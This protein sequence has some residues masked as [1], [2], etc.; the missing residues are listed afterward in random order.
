VADQPDAVLD[1]KSSHFAHVDL[2]IGLDE[3]PEHWRQGTPVP[4][5]EVEN[6]KK[7]DQQTDNERTNDAH[8]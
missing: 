2:R 7:R 8:D 6:G 3:P 4:M 5:L 1:G